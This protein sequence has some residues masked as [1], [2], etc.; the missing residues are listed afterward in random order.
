MVFRLQRS[1]DSSVT[2]QRV[3]SIQGH[4]GCILKSAQWKPIVLARPTALR[5]RWA[6]VLSNVG[7]LPLLKNL[8]DDIVIEEQ[9]GEN[10]HW[11]SAARSE[12]ASN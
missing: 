11:Q 10:L 4:C 1:A 6:V 5:F 3:V 9:V 12:P 7:G 8:A 2:S